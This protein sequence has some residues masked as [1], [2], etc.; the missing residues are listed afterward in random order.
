MIHHHIVAV[1]TGI[2]C[3]S[4]NHTWQYGTDWCTCRNSNVNTSVTFCLSG[5]G[6]A[7]ISKLRSDPAFPPGANR[8]AEPIRPDKGHLCPWDPP[9]CT[10][11]G[12]VLH[13]IIDA[14]RVI[15]LLLGDGNPHGCLD[16]CPHFFHIGDGNCHHVGLLRLYFLVGFIGCGY[17]PGAILIGN[18]AVRKLPMGLA[19]GRVVPKVQ[20]IKNS[21]DPNGIKACPVFHHIVDFCHAIIQ[22]CEA[23]LHVR[24]VGPVLRRSI[25]RQGAAIKAQ[26]NHAGVVLCRSAQDGTKDDCQQDDR[27]K[28]HGQRPARRLACPFICQN[29]RCR[30][31]KYCSWGSH[32]R[33]PADPK[34]FSLCGGAWT[35]RRCRSL[36]HL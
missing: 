12:A 28:N 9:F 4:R 26:V 29:S 11:G 3:G 31:G 35:A 23:L 21:L 1:A 7:A 27:R 8:R 19:A 15:A 20:G 18:K 6:I 16:V 22:P 17:R 33:P 36:P 32:Q 13:Q 10:S 14:V 24:N 25:F 34:S 5:E 2:V 30:S